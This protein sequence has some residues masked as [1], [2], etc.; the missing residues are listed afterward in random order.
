MAG[1]A[2]SHELYLVSKNRNTAGKRSYTKIGAGWEKFDSGMISI[3][4]QPGTVLDHNLL[5]SFYLNL[6]PVGGSVPS[7]GSG[8]GYDDDIPF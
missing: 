4:I 2:P 7:S 1:Q 3:T 6:Q 8:N 5:E